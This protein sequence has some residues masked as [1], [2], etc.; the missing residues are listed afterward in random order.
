MQV[1]VRELGVPKPGCFKTAVVCHFY[2]GALL[3]RCA[4]LR[5]CAYTLLLICGHF[6]SFACFCV[7]PNRIWELQARGAQ[8]TETEP[9]GPGGRLSKSTSALDCL[10]TEPGI[11]PLDRLLQANV[12]RDPLISDA[13][14][15]GADG[16]KSFLRAVCLRGPKTHPISTYQQ[17]LH[18]HELFRRVGANSCLLPCDASQERDLFRKLV[19]TNFYLGWILGEWIFLL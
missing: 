10:P 16:G 15:G 14:D 12:R 2:A 18:L 17:T 8:S 19:Q 13:C 11:L 9:R 3:V 7:R 6:R 5:P 4:L 1:V